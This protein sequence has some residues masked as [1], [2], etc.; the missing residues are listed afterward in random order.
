MADA[1]GRIEKLKK[2]INKYR[3]DYHV[4]NKETISIEALDSLKH[5]LKKL[6]DEY[7]EL[8]TPDS[9]TQRVAGEPLKGFKKITHRVPMLSLEDVFSEEEFSDWEKRIAKLLHISYTT[10]L[11][12]ELKFDGLAVSLVYKNGVLDYA[13]TRGNGKV[14][15]DVTQ[16]IKTIEAIPLRLEKDIKGEVEIRGEVIITRK[17]FEKINREQKKKGEAVYA[18]PRNLAAGSLR[19]LDPKMTASRA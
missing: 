14:G 3:Y 4:L 12:S 15:E 5:E 7:P 11:F 10:E 2:A 19:Q 13:S 6:E 1:K 18:N 9:P 17:G 16:N 8:V